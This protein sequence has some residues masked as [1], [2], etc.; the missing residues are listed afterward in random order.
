MYIPT[1]TMELV[2]KYIFWTTHIYNVI[3]NNKEPQS[4][5]SLV[6]TYLPAYIVIIK[7]LTTS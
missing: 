5:L 2:G 4:Y 7:K 1:W 3:N 6:P